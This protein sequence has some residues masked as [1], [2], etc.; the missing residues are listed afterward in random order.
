[1]SS[2]IDISETGSIFGIPQGSMSSSIDI[3]E[4]WI[5][6]WHP[7]GVYVI[8]YGHLRSLDLFLA[9]HRGL[10]LLLL[11][12]QRSGSILGIPQGIMSSSMDISE[13][14]IYSWHATGVYVF[15]Y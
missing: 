4:V 2:S 8:F 13:V 5:Y 11:T 1:M 6:F 15:F 7:T 12:S 14:W 10:C 3:S 9:S